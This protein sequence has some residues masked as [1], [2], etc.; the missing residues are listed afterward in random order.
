MVSDQ[1]LSSIFILKLC[2]LF[3]CSS[4]VTKSLADQQQIPPIFVNLG[5]HL[6]SLKTESSVRFI[7]PLAEILSS[8]RLAKQLAAISSEIS[9]S[10]I[11]IFWSV[12]P[13]RARTAFTWTVSIRRNW[14]KEI[15][16]YQTF[17]IALVSLLT[18]LFQA[19][20]LQSG[21]CFWMNDL[22]ISQARLVRYEGPRH[23]QWLQVGAETVK[24][25]EINC[26][27][28]TGVTKNQLK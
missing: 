20:F 16:V 12:N 11:L 9:A 6:I 23:W 4:N 27:M 25:I 14:R 2:W 1:S 7:G 5:H 24:F 21:E 18:G 15:F 10:V 17:P 13:T 3:S 28:S 26:S 22:S 19:E 8:S